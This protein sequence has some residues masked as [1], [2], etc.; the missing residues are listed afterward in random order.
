M[1]TITPLCLATDV[2]MILSSTGVSLRTDDDSDATD[3]AIEEASLDIQE[4]CLQSYSIE[5]LTASNWVKRQTAWRAAKYLCE[6]RG[7]PVPASLLDEVKRR[8]ERLELVRIGKLRIPDAVKRKADIPVLTNQRTR[9]QPF[10][11]AVSERGRS[12]GTPDGYTPHDDRND[13]FDYS[14]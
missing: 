10:P 4:Y 14:L 12:T 8:E 3:W 2:E 1:P 11:Q 7:N 6:R 5:S 9:V 13:W